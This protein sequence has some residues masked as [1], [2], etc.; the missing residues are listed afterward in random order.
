MHYLK[1]MEK[2]DRTNPTYKALHRSKKVD[3]NGN[4]IKNGKVGEGIS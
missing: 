4:E 3:A 2:L 1:A